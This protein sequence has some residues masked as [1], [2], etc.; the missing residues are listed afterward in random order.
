MTSVFIPGQ[1]RTWFPSDSMSVVIDTFLIALGKGNCLE[2]IL[3]RH[4]AVRNTH[5]NGSA[6]LGSDYMTGLGWSHC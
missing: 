6:P 3:E 2:Y 1:H 4:A 5:P